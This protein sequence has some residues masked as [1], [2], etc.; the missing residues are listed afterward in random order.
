[1][2]L[3][4]K[5]DIYTQALN[6]AFVNAYDAIA[7]P[8]P[9]E[10]ALTEVPSKGRVENYPWLYPPPFLRQWKGYRRY[11]KLGETNYRV[12]N[13]TY[14]AE[15]ECL[16]ED[17]DDDQI[18]GFKRQAAAMAQGAR[19]YKGIQTLQTLALG[20]TTP[21]FDGTNFFA[22]SHTVGTGNNIVSAAAA[23]S[24]GQT[25]AM[26]ALIV[27]NKVVKPLLWQQREGPDFKTDAGSIDSSKTRMVKWWS[28]LRGAA[29]FGF[30]WDAILCKWA[31]TPTVAEVQ[32]ALGT[33]NARFRGF[34]YPTN[35]ADDPAQYP[36]GQLVFD[37]SSLV[38][39]CSTLIEHLVRQALTLSLIA[40]TENYYKGFAKLLCSGYL[41]GIT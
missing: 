7:E 6:T 35:Q 9:I 17:L 12:P 18:D 4:D 31:N 5:I 41:D 24:D 30:W 32:T 21:C 28:D 8:A 22:S 38:I 37:D 20:Q 25:H 19:E 23:A 29:A 27:K 1:V 2:A 39:V 11:A 14:T 40:Q 36:H 26:T 33:I 15:F 3:T 10:V 16:L 34:K 13:L